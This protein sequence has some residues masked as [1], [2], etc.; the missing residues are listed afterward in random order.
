MDSERF[1]VLDGLISG[2]AASSG[3]APETASG[4]A[5]AGTPETAP[6]PAAPEPAPLEP[7][8]FAS[9]PAPQTGDP[10]VDEA[11]AGL[12]GLGGRPLDEHPGALEAAHDTLREIL[13]ELGEPGKPGR[14]GTQGEL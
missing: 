1:S 9:I 11:V 5:P 3:E 7:A 8:G 12:A 4:P 10:R 13:G 14:P 6:D 2:P